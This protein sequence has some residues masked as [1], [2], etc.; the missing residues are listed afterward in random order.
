MQLLNLCKFYPGMLRDLYA[1]LF[2]VIGSYVD[3]DDRLDRVVGKNS[4]LHTRI[5]SSLCVTTALFHHWY[6][7]RYSATKVQ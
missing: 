5:R 4:S 6:H 7:H 2:N 1:M 3:T